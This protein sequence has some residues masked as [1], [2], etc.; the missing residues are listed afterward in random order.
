MTQRTITRLAAAALTVFIT[1]TVA[2][3]TPGTL[4]WHFAPLSPHGW[5]YPFDNSPAVARD[6]TVYVGD[7]YDHLW[8]INPDGTEKWMFQ[9]D[10]YFEQG[11]PSVAADG[12]VYAID[13]HNILYA[14]N[15]D[16]SLRWMIPDPDYAYINGTPAIGPDGTIYV[17]ARDDTIDNLF[18]FNPDG[19]KKWSIMTPRYITSSTTIGPDGTIY[20]HSNSKYL[21]AYRPDGSFIWQFDMGGDG[22]IEYNQSSPAIGPDGALYVGGG[23]WTDPALYAV[24]PDGTQRWRFPTADHC[25]SS[26]TIGPD[27]TIYV[28]DWANKLY[29]VNPDG[30]IKW[31]YGTG[32]PIKGAPAVGSDGTIYVGSGDDYLYAINPDGTRQWRQPGGRFVSSPAIGPDGVVYVAGRY[33]VYAYYTSSDGPADTTWPMYQQNIRH[34][35]T[36]EQVVTPLT[37]GD[38]VNATIPANGVHY[39]SLATAVGESLLVELSAGTGSTALV[40]TGQ[41]EATTYSSP[42]PAA[43]G[44]YELL[45]TP[46]AEAEYLLSV[47]G[48]DVA[49]NGGDYSLTADYVAQHLSDVDPRSGGDA[50]GVTLRITGLGFTEPMA[51][52]LDGPA[53]IPA[54]EIT[55]SA[56]SELMA[57]FDL[58]GATLGSYDL[59]VTWPDANWSVLAD[60]FEV[61]PGG[62]AVLD[63]WLEAPEAARA[64]RRYVVW[65]HYAN[66]GDADM[67]APLFEVTANV[68]LSLDKEDIVAD[69]VGVLGTG[70]PA[71]PD[72]LRAGESRRI[73][74]YFIAPATG[75]SIFSLAE[76][77]GTGDPVDWASKKDAMRPPDMDPADWDAIWPDL[78]ARLGTTWG[79]YLQVLR[80]AA[81]RVGPRGQDP[82][83]V[84]RL[85]RIEMRLA[86]GLPVAAVAGELRH[87]ITGEPLPGVTL[88]LISLDG[89]VVMETET[90]YTP[91][92][93]F[94]FEEVP[95][96][97]YEIYVEGYFFDPTPAVAVT[98]VDVVGLSLWAE[99]FPEQEEVPLPEMAQHSPGMTSD[100]AGTLYL[101]WESEGQIWWARNSGSGWTQHGAIPDA[102]G[103]RPVVAYDAGLL[104]SGATEGLFVAWE[105][106]SSPESDPVPQYLQ[107]AV[108]E[109]GPDGMTWSVPESL[110]S[111]AYDDL[112][113]AVAV[114]PSQQALVV[115]LQRDFEVVDDTDLYFS[116][117]DVGTVT[118]LVEVD[119]IDAGLAADASAEV[120][121]TIPLP[122]E[123][124]LAGVPILGGR[125]QFELGGSVC[126]TMGCSPSLS[127]IGTIKVK[128]GSKIEVS[129]EGNLGAQWKADPCSCD[130]VFDKANAQLTTTVALELYKWEKVWLVYGIIPVGRLTV[131]PIVSAS[132]QGT[133]EWRSNFPDWPDQ[134]DVALT[135]GGTLEGQLKG[136][137]GL[138]AAKVTGTA[139]LQGKYSRPPIDPCEY[140]DGTWC[141]EGYCLKFQVDLSALYGFAGIK[142]AIYQQHGP[143]CPPL[144][145]S[146]VLPFMDAQ[147]SVDEWRFESAY[148]DDATETVPI[149]EEISYFKDGT[150]GTGSDYEGLPVLGDISSD[151]RQD[152]APVLAESAAGEILVVWAKD[153]E[154]ALLGSRIWVA[155]YGAGSWGTPD[156]LSPTV[157]F[158]KDPTIVFDSAG[159]PMVVWATASNAGLDWSTSSVE[160]I[161]AA[162]EAT[163]LVFVRRIGGVWSAPATLASL[164]GRDEQVVLAAG[165]SG[166]VTAAWVNESASGW[167]VYASIWNGATWSTPEAVATPDLTYKPAVA[168]QGTTPILVWAQDDDGDLETSDDWKLYTAEWSGSSWSTP[169]PLG[170]AASGTSMKRMFTRPSRG[171]LIGP[172]EPDPDECCEGG[173][174]G[175]PPSPPGGPDN[176]L[177]GDSTPTVAPID[178]NEKTGPTGI[179]PEQSIDAGDRLD[180]VV[181]FEN[182]PAAA[183]PAQE[184]FVTDCLDHDLDWSS[185]TLDEIAFGDVVV[186]NSSGEP[187]FDT[188]VTIPDHRPAEDKSWWVDVTSEFDLGTGCLDVTFRTIDPATGE[189]PEDVFAGFLP[190]EDGTG[191]GQGHIALSVDSKPDLVDGTVITNRGSIIFDVNEAI[192]TN[193]WFN[194][195]GSPTSPLLTVTVA[196]SGSGTVTSNP[197]GIDC[198]SDCYE[199]YLQG[200]EVNLHASAD[201]GSVFGGWIGGGCSGT[202]TFCEVTMNESTSVTA[203]FEP[204]GGCGLSESMV[205]EGM[206]ID[207]THLFEACTTITAG[208]G[209]DVTGTADVTLRAGQSVV[210][211]NGFA[212][213]AGA[214]LTVDI[215]PGVGSP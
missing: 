83:D 9:A 54:A 99:D 67:P 16:G 10:Y 185:A 206:T 87:A 23:D 161:L 173:D 196:G 46:T 129:V 170:M 25:T 106:S 72:V 75:D 82:Y 208:N 17:G 52:E 151:V 66:V 195:I 55:V 159:D 27:G 114:D 150:P 205:L 79:D 189:L 134:A 126:G 18:A 209:L 207:D 138:V 95:D 172:P 154:P 198:E 39:Y 163:D 125:Y 98:G 140:G 202:G 68:P 49:E 204:E 103:A 181:Y 165:P 41:L 145:P 40:L 15:P 153:E 211:T 21:E 180:Y 143:S 212:L 133:M 121:L 192:V 178:P 73:P 5:P 152:W 90:S 117:V 60:A 91:P 116:E 38:T 3:Q 128:L 19:S 26:P 97:N 47:Y 93:L 199:F 70:G 168:Y 158:H 45:I 176:P 214:S 85:L 96:D 32:G 155:G 215:D 197:L 77:L 174:C 92:G 37:V 58:A 74:I 210:L 193:E 78:V 108:G 29:A 69:R 184:V 63:A 144:P 100:G 105:R 24:N 48:R 65:L 11:S 6:G 187:L 104:D 179:G 20:V 59:K 84:E 22:W 2:A 136:L 182:L 186:G 8:A 30:T 109:I 118:L 194:T 89:T 13:G 201:P 94:V 56:E 119:P 162:L 122:G 86:A 51:V 53:T 113:V 175:S 4:K 71:S 142:K 183:V 141:F 166:E 135:V 61:V 42:E 188:Q 190:P 50:G 191:R 44:P 112:G 33:G 28:G 107:W 203:I 160:E 80:D 171:A 149:Y 101:V 111:D 62:G 110:T 137:E 200:T 64:L 57:R 36:W 177:G 124:C 7:F 169:V 132:A 157:D 148:L 130:F 156:V 1:G 88:R 12:T 120:C 14:L 146:A 123:D 81:A 35:G 167:T 164:A 76:I 31:Q 213:E 115:W 139:E 131:R 102:N 34:T 43:A 147:S 127:Y